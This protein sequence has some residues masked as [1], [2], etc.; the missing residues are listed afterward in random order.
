MVQNAQASKAPIQH[1]VDKISAVFVPVVL[2]IAL[3]AFIFWLV[4][5]S[6]PIALMTGIGVLVIACPCALGLATPMGVIVG[7]GK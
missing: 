6:L 1:L 4:F 7:V 2:V 5:G 3:G